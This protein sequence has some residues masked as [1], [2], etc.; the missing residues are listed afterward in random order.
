M[1][2]DLS[3][4]N[5]TTRR[6]RNMK[7]VKYLKGSH[8]RAIVETLPK[9]VSFPIYPQDVPRA[10]Y[11][12]QNK[13]KQGINHSL[14]NG[15]KI[16]ETSRG[17]YA[18]RKY[19]T[20]DRRTSQGRTVAELAGAY[21]SVL[22]KTKKPVIRYFR[23]PAF[24]YDIDEAEKPRRAERIQYD[25]RTYILIHEGEEISAP[26]TSFGE[27][28]K[29]GTRTTFNG[30][31][32]YVVE[33]ERHAYDF[34]AFL[35]TY[36]TAQNK[37]LYDWNVLYRASQN[38]HII[39]FYLDTIRKNVGH[40][41]LIPSFI[42][43][44]TTYPVG[45]GVPLLDTPFIQYNI[46]ENVER[47]TD[48]VT[49]PKI[50]DKLDVCL[51][52]AIYQVCCDDTKF[53]KK[54]KRK[55]WQLMNEDYI[56]YMWSLNHPD[57][58]RPEVIP[59]ATLQE[60]F[61]TFDVLQKEIVVFDMRRKVWYKRLPKLMNK[62]QNHFHYVYDDEGNTIDNKLDENSNTKTLYFI[63]HNKHVYHVNRPFK[64]RGKEEEE[65]YYGLVD[66]EPATQ[67]TVDYDLPKDDEKKE[68]KEDKKNKDA[69]SDAPRPAPPTV[70]KHDEETPWYDDLARIVSD[71]EGDFTAY[72]F[73]L[74]L[75]LFT[76]FYDLFKNTAYEATTIASNTE[77]CAGLNMS[78]FWRGGVQLTVKVKP[79]P[80]KLIQHVDPFSD[81]AQD[82]IRAFIEEEKAL[83]AK[84][85]TRSVLS[86]YSEPTR[87]MFNHYKAG[88][89]R[90]TFLTDEQWEEL[91]KKFTALGFDFA[92]HYPFIMC[93]FEY[94]PVFSVFD[95]PQKYDGHAIEAYTFYEVRAKNPIRFY[96]YRTQHLALGWT[97]L[98]HL[99]E[100]DYNFKIISFLRPSRLAPNHYM[101][102]VK[103]LVERS[104]LHIGILKTLLAKMSGLTGISAYK[105]FGSQVYF[106]KEEA[107]HYK[108]L[109]PS[110]ES[111]I[112]YF[113]GQDGEDVDVFALIQ[114][115]QRPT[116]SGFMPVYLA[117]IDV[118]MYLPY[119]LKNKLTNLGYEVIGMKTDNVYINVDYNNLPAKLKLLEELK[120]MMCDYEVV[121][122][123]IKFNSSTFE[124]F[125]QLKFEA[126]KL[127]RDNKPI[128]IKAKDT[129]YIH[130][131][132]MIFEPEYPR[133]ERRSSPD[134]NGY[135][136]MLEKTLRL[137]PTRVSP[138]V[139]PPTSFKKP[140]TDHSQRLREE[141]AK[142]DRELEER[143]KS[144]YYPRPLL[145]GVKEWDEEAFFKTLDR[146]RERQEHTQVLAKYAGCGKTTIA[147][148][149][150]ISRNL[151]VV[152]LSFMN[153]KVCE[154]REDFGDYPNVICSTIDHLF[155]SR[156]E[157]ILR[158]ADM[159]LVD[160]WATTPI[161]S[162]TKL[163]RAMDR[164]DIKWLVVTSDVHQN[165][166]INKEYNN[167]SNGNPA[168]VSDNPVEEAEEDDEEIQHGG[169]DVE[170]YYNDLTD[171][172]CPAKI[173]LKEPKR[174][175]CPKHIKDYDLPT[176]RDCA[177]CAEARR[178]WAYV[179]D[180]I[181]N[182]P[183]DLDARNFVIKN[184]APIYKLSDI[185]NSN[186][187]TYF[188]KTRDA[189]NKFC[190][191]RVITEKGMDASTKYYE[192]QTI[193]CQKRYR[194]K[195][196]S[197]H[198][199]Y[200]ATVLN[201]GDTGEVTLV[202]PFTGKTF[203]P[204]R[205]HLTKLFRYSHAITC[206]SKQGSSVDTP[207][208]IFNIFSRFVS[209]N[210]LLVAVTRNVDFK[211]TRVYLGGDLKTMDSPEGTYYA[212]LTS[213][214]DG[215]EL[216][217][218][219]ARIQSMINRHKTADKN[220]GRVWNPKQYITV[221]YIMDLLGKTTHCAVCGCDSIDEDS[222]SIDRI[223]SEPAHIK[224][225]VQ[226][227]CSVECNASKKQ[228]Y[229]SS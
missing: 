183:T 145:Y 35:K 157:A 171:R 33:E 147:I 135:L 85:L 222:F 34:D 91:P 6:V 12:G 228:N 100:D 103:A 64:V 108:A 47:F 81:E 128:T 156:K 52:K 219:R 125:G 167:I 39:V 29:L 46:N 2:V 38:A 133:E 59:M 95:V 26:M 152:A 121:G 163:Q 206:H 149:Y 162:A 49:Q 126:I 43:D 173:L 61:P 65:D 154:M 229:I 18:V 102:E 4:K 84:I 181:I 56:G 68:Q 30:R 185:T 144:P 224:G 170:T 110:A 190:H 175:R 71:P 225:N 72:T 199:N 80:Y 57:E 159:V 98:Q 123:D 143:M 36:P 196:V 160:E 67:K 218:L 107:E 58:P 176:I 127:Y 115:T 45:R 83:K 164:G 129:D 93:M 211:Q 122:D 5:A 41:T 10:V 172:L 200:D 220:A 184:F 28:I 217:K 140:P 182:A 179:C 130:N 118:A 37:A 151:K 82:I 215:E 198:T 112:K 192:G 87:S 89:I 209:K 60:F 201:I 21:D 120:P 86:Q 20:I 70:L 53:Q 174:C 216:T 1:K 111:I 42:N 138:L 113:Q 48:L 88:G 119:R 136:N 90:G 11:N 62:H 14:P 188:C 221:K 213:A 31:P 214:K 186:N 137:R 158:E 106:D 19:N 77:T 32:A 94:L 27:F 101:A 131:E 13:L 204:S 23:V 134:F 132:G 189:I 139:L 17:N 223:D 191:R 3:W 99:E 166:A 165:P 76:A 203:T 178:E 16:I 75:P 227:L 150:A 141:R 124:N 79:F 202:E 210:W 180:S 92:K 105:R 50:D 177:D 193:V 161:P 15:F 142:I 66:E 7:N 63:I 44:P 54:G 109:M 146:L 55:Q 148:R 169:Y 104:D 187:I 194:T 25:E 73:Y 226:I 212:D 205:E 9:P 208:T 168:P 22:T 8:A 155:E 51:Y 96:A 97:L 116:H 207:V 117:I 197:L 69:D 40:Q 195:E 78:N 74:A 153:R 114:N 24:V